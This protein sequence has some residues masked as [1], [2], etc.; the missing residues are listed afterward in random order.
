MSAVTPEH[1]PPVPLHP[2]AFCQPVG[3]WS[4]PPAVHAAGAHI[5][6][7]GLNGGEHR[8]GQGR[9]QNFVLRINVCIFPLKPVASKGK[10]QLSD[11]QLEEFYLQGY[12][13]RK[14]ILNVS[15]ALCRS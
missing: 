13:N 8:G 6:E 10:L 7:V 14:Q 9:R 12:L 11:Y 4:S 5:W 1:L 3:S 2:S 15:A